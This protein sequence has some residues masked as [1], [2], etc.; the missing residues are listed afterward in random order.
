[1]TIENITG[2]ILA[3]A[4]AQSSQILEEAD[5]KSRTIIE[6][7]QEQAEKIQKDL[8]E[9]GKSDAQLLKS[10]RTSVAKLEARKMRLGAKQA[11]ISRCFDSALDQ[12]ANMAE[13]DY[14]DFLASKILAA[15]IDGGELLLNERDRKAIG[16]KLVKK[17]NGTGETGTLTLSANII[18]AKGGFVLRQGSVEFNSTLETMVSSIRESITPDVVKALFD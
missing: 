3:E 10:R 12:L 16:E 13:S 18:K 9:Q 5:Y 17:V 15:G 11:L 4:H 8:A 7:A 2:K 6:K 1:M 14:L